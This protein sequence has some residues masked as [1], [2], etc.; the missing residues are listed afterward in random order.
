MIPPFL[1]CF[2]F[3]KFRKILNFAKIKPSRYFLNLK[4]GSIFHFF[5]EFLLFYQFYL[6]YPYQPVEKIRTP[7]PPQKKKKKKKKKTNSRTSAAR[8]PHVDPWRYHGHCNVKI[9]SPCRISAYS[10]FSGSLFSCFSYLKYGVHVFSGE[11]EKESITLHLCEDGME[12]FVPRD[13]RLSPLGEPRGA[14]RWSSGR[15]FLSHPHTHDL[16][17]IHLNIQYRWTHRADA[18]HRSDRWILH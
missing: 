3:A 7:P 5:L 4:Y 15:F 10:G 17:S 11:Q 18:S 13:H 14:N 9:T 12:K 8:W 2:I 6:T 16:T 1:E